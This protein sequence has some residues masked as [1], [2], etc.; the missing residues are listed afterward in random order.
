M[1][2]STDRAH[3]TN[4]ETSRKYQLLGTYHNTR[5]HCESFT[6]ESDIIFHPA[7]VLSIKI[8][9]VR[10]RNRNNSHYVRKN[11]FKRIS[12]TCAPPHPY[13]G[14]NNAECYSRGCGLFQLVRCE[15][16]QHPHTMIM[17]TMIKIMSDR[18]YTPTFRIREV[19][20]S[21][22]DPETGNSDRLLVVSFSPPRKVLAHYLQFCQS[23]FLTHPF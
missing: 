9:S 11:N 21:N 12:K 20:G 3:G 14:L 17:I 16:G 18:R 8:T 15:H 7:F 10:L 22:V 1:V 4:L 19:S 13:A 23:R 6:Y 5:I 2:T